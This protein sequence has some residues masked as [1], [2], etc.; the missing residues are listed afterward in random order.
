MRLRTPIAI[1]TVVAALPAQ[2]M[3]RASAADG[4]DDLV[5]EG[6][7]AFLAADT[8]R[9]ATFYDRACP[10]DS[11]GTYAIARA[12]TCENLLASV[13]EARG[14][15][16]RAEQRYLHAVTTAE[17]AGP[18]YLPLYCARLI[19]LGEYYG[20][21]GQPATAESRLHQAADIA[22]ALGTVRPELLPEALIRLGRLYSWSDQPERGRAPL[23]E[24]LVLAQALEGGA[25]PVPATEIA[26]SRSSLGMIELAA[27]HQR[28][29]E[30]NLREAVAMAGRVLGEDNPLTAAYQTN[31]ALTLL[32]DR[33]FSDADLLLRRARFVVE[34]QRN[35]SEAE[36]AAIFAELSAANAGQGKM[37]QAEEYSE[38]AIE[39]LK[40]Q[41]RPD[42]RAVAIA[43]V[44]LA[45]AH[46]G[47]HRVE[48]AE[49]ILPGAVE[50]LRRTPVHPVTLANAVQLLGQLREQQRNWQAAET[51]YREALGMY[52]RNE[53]AGGNPAVGPL[54][55]AL[56]GV[57][58]HEGGRKDEIHV[59]ES[60]A[61]EILRT[62]RSATPRA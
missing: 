9:A 55:R 47:S 1:L 39:I 7:A 25:T 21:H 61:R 24:A 54:L 10:A 34:S 52:E 4:F 56:A 20:R 3:L 30:A 60:R 23:T 35:P 29:A 28:E 48:A 57:L 45:S 44:T 2:S 41:S 50:S 11:A 43:Q 42:K 38:R 13:D 12:V 27:G 49:E 36:L 6:R 19:D 33:R 17:Q 22:R 53:N 16:A 58:R 62:T 14:N 46:L 32:A 59:L 15:L 40:R 37:S 51:L 31:L 8:E 5:K 18:A 26:Y